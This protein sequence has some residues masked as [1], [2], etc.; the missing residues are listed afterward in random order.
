R[1]GWEVLGT[2]IPGGTSLGAPSS[3]D[4]ADL[5]ATIRAEGVRVIFTETSSPDDL[6]RVIAEEV[7]DQIDVVS[8]HTESLAESPADTLIG[9]LEENARRITRSILDRN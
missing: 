1:Y 8:L 5:V 9:M 4:L 6:A 3:A 2:V 7:G